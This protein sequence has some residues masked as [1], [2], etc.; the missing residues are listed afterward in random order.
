MSKHLNLTA[1]KL[2]NCSVK[3]KNKYT[4]MVMAADLPKGSYVPSKGQLLHN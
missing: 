4:H 3:M 1:P 2:L